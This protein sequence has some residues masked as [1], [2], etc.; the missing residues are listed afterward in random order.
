MHYG[1]I[2]INHRTLIGGNCRI[3]ACVN[4]GESGGEEGVPIISLV[5]T[6]T[7]GQVRKFKAK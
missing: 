5:T 4:S 1:T 7:L 2:I 6:F 3:H